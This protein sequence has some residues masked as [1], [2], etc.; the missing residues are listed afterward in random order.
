MPNRHVHNGD[1]TLYVEDRG[2]GLPLVLLHGFPET[3][4]SW[5]HQMPVLID[6]GYRCIA[7]DQRGYGTASK[8]D[9]LDDYRLE[10]LVGDVIAVL[11]T[12]EV[13]KATLIGHDWGSIVLW[14]TAVLH[15][16]RID[17]LVSLNVPYRGACWGFPTTDVIRELLADRFSYVLRFLDGDRAERDF[18][19]DP[20][21][22]LQFFYLTAA[23][24]DDF[25]S[26]EEF[27]RYLDAFVTGGVTGPVSWYRNIDRNAEDLAAHLGARIDH[28]T[29][30]LAADADPVLP[31]SL[32]D[33]MERWVP[34]STRVVIED[35]G[36]W[37]QQERPEQ[38]NDALLA[39]LAAGD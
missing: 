5:R 35:C 2:G 25:M 7:F 23:K 4:F 9:A 32:T 18:G 26:G 24:R 37:T 28:P 19:A 33:G 17:R 27:D 8:P 6:A 15:P 39:W 16:E 14:S 38:V 30:L 12:L 36:H 13:E 10:A 1:V 20:A 31:L 11:D 34:N 3:A 22:W 29:L 21:R